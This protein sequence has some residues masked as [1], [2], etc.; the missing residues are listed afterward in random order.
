MRHLLALIAVVSLAVAATAAAQQR[1]GEQ[2]PEPLFVLTGGGWGHNVGLSQWGAYGQAQAGRTYDRI[3]RHYFVGTEL[4]P[5]PIRKVRVLVADGTRATTIASTAFFRVRDATGAVR[6]VTGNEIHLT[7]AMR[8]PVALPGQ[9]PVAPPVTKRLKLTPPLTFLPAQGAT[10]ALDGKGF[11]GRFV[12]ARTGKTLRIVMEV[13]LEAYVMGIVPGEMP[14]EWPLEAL[15]AQAVAARTYAVANLEQ[16]K[17]WDVVADPQSFAY[18]GVDAESPATTKAVQQTRGQVLT[19]HGQ[20]ISAFYFS[21][22]GGR[23]LSAQDVFGVALPYLPGADDPWDAASPHHQ[24]TVRTFTPAS[25]GRALGIGSQVDDLQVVPSAPGRPLAFLITTRAGQSV[26]MRSADVRA[27]LG[28]KSP[29]FRIGV[30]R[31]GPPQL[32][33]AGTTVTLEGVARDVGPAMLEQRDSN[34]VWK[35]ARKLLLQP[36]GSFALALRPA[37]TSAYR[38]AAQGLIGPSVVVTVIPARAAP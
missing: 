10:L 6:Q 5:A 17:D 38:L 30:L 13:S 15:K 11:R 32:A 26:P 23:T 9:G 8:V 16:G 19:Y 20:V 28:L 37:G 27:R 31:I 18:Y 12:V 22:S 24:W 35:Q 14:K 25:L 3:L 36:D 34:G 2:A 1:P 4:T 21:S 29:N 33:A 7:P